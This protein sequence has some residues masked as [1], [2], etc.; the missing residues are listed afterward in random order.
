MAPQDDG[1][2]IHG[3]GYVAIY[4][5]YV[6]EEIDA[7]LEMLSPVEAVDG[8]LRKQPASKKL[9]AIKRRL[10]KLNDPKLSGLPA[11]LDTCADLLEARN[12]I[13][14]GRIYAVPGR[15]DEL[16]SG[17]PGNPTRP[18]S[19]IECYELANALGNCRALLRRPRI[20]D[21]PR[22]LGGSSSSAS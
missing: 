18:V 21:L 1:D 20:F 12:E 6:E 7:L 5:A 16:H 10:A 15:P 9:K 8:S 19:S 14:H 3:I 11:D 22:A 2:L 4:A 17:R 13:L